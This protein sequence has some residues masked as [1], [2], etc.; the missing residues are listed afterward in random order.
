MWEMTFAQRALQEL[1]VKSAIF[2]AY[3]GLDNIQIQKNM[4]ARLA[5]I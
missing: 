1:Y 3:I 2:M 5:Q 4:F